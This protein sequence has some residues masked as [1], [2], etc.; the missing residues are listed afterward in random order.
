[1]YLSRAVRLSAA[2]T[3]A[4]GDFAPGS[5]GFGDLE[6]PQTKMDTN[7][8]RTVFGIQDEASF[9]ICIGYG[10]KYSKTVLSAEQCQHG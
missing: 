5:G 2:A 8:N 10:V 9:K 4:V 7:P 6:Q 1:M 3:G